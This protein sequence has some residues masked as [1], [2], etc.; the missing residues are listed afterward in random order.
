M[1]IVLEPR[2][3]NEISSIDFDPHW[4]V[5]N[6]VSTSKIEP[7]QNNLNVNEMRIDFDPHWNL[8]NYVSTCK[9]KRIS[10]FSQNPCFQCLL[11]MK[12]KLM[13]YT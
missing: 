5:D 11:R 1:R 2:C 7:V 12:K 4:N 10:M 13:N 3:P 8:D 6:Y 9:I